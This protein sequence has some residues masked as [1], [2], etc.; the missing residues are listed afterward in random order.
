M[1]YRL[2]PDSPG[3]AAAE[4]VQSVVP[5]SENLR[6]PLDQLLLR[7]QKR[8]LAQT[9]FFR[10]L[11]PELFSF[12]ASAGSLL[13]YTKCLRLWPKSCAC[14]F[15]LISWRIPG[16]VPRGGAQHTR[17]PRNGAQGTAHGAWTDRRNRSME[18]QDGRTGRSSGSPSVYTT[19]GTFCVYAR[20]SANIRAHCGIGATRRRE[21]PVK[22]IE[23]PT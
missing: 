16:L 8:A 13:L 9:R 18:Q 3:R 2:I 14:D 11:F 20:T 15:Q 5:V 17:R 12:F 21:S 19:W 4:R 10:L 23:I 1:I 7:A 22:S 6:I